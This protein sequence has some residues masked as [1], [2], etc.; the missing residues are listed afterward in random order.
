M[1]K[2]KGQ[3]EKIL[4]LYE[5]FT[6]ESDENHR[7]TLQDMIDYLYSYGLICERKSVYEYIDILR[8]FGLDIVCVHEKRYY[9]YLRERTFENA[10]LK[11]LIDIVQSS[12]L[13]TKKKSVTLIEKLSSLASRSD[14][15]MLKREVTV[16]N[17]VKHS[18]EKVYENIDRIN[19]AINGRKLLSFKYYK[20]EI[21]KSGSSV[22]LKKVSRRGDERY[23]VIPKSLM[24]DDE[25]YYLVAYEYS[26]KKLR[27]YRVD[28]M[29]KLIVSDNDWGTLKG[30]EKFDPGSYSKQVFG[31]Y[32]GEQREVTVR[33]ENSLI[34]VVVDRFGQKVS[35]TDVDDKS[36]TVKISVMLSPQFFAWLFAFSD[37]AEILSPDDAV[38]M[39]KKYLSDVMKKY[40]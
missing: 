30:L 5:L 38:D 26:T 10:E 11:L 8:N 1:A 28:R 17:R 2:S 24:W 27:H 22:T 31:M 19:E 16:I 13:I 7:Y 40:E 15:D 33:F 6:K 35:I 34:G 29:E 3:Q 12:K 36:F 14:A 20:W 23:L 9:Y 32:G 18:N 39:M 4:R 25:N 21:R 37:K